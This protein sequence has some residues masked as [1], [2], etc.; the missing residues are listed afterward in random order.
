MTATACSSDAFQ[1]SLGKNKAWIYRFSKELCWAQRPAECNQLQGLERHFP[2]C[3]LTCEAQ[4]QPVEDQ[5][6]FYSAAEIAAGWCNPANW[7][8]ISLIATAEDTVWGHYTQ[9]GTFLG[10]FSLLM[11]E[12]K[13]EFS[14]SNFYPHL[15]K[16]N[17]IPFNDAFLFS[18]TMETLGFL[19]DLSSI[20]HWEFVNNSPAM[21]EKRV[22]PFLLESK[23][24]SLKTK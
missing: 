22:Q 2:L 16:S 6:S 7:K 24:K 11:E 17:G 12:G 5:P 8:I 21:L 1:A 23:S 18:D 10:F 3:Y 4:C 13:N 19:K 9:V 20:I 15:C 14:L